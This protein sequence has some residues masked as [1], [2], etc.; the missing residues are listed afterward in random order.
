M[1]NL[2]KN[3]LGRLLEIRHPTFIAS[4]SDDFILDKKGCDICAEKIENNTYKLYDGAYHSLHV[5]IPA[6]RQKFF[7]DLIEWTTTFTNS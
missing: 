7:A 2:A 1:L 4:G 5:E 3:V 6:T